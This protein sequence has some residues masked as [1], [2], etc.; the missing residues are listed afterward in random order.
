L[1][2]NGI[3]VDAIRIRA[4]PFGEEVVQFIHSHSTVFVIEQNRDA[5]LRSMMIMEL[6]T[7]PAK[8]I[9]VLNYD[10]MPITADSIKNQILKHLN[11]ENTQH[12]ELSKTAL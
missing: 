11:L 8:L 2:E 10:G 5:Q 12:H 4:F 7:N 1:E 3:I 6:E 9:P